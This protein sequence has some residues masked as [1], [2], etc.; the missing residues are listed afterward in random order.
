[1]INKEGIKI[2]FSLT[3]GKSAAQEVT[4]QAVSTA[5]PS[6]GM[7]YVTYSCLAQTALGTSF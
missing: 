5:R 3:E 6:T 7:K 2:D 1:M 4:G